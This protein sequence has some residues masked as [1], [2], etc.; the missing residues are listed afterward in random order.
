MGGR[1]PGRLAGLAAGGLIE[2]SRSTQG[3]PAGP[4][5]AFGGES[6]SEHVRI[7][8]DDGWRLS[9]LK[10]IVVHVG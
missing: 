6:V 1:E 7:W 4:H 5:L 3:R 10:T 2:R 9:E 8:I